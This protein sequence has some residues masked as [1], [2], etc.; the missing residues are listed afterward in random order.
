VKKILI[1][2]T[3]P[4]YFLE[5]TLRLLEVYKDEFYGVSSV[6][7]VDPFAL[8]SLSSSLTPMFKNIET[9]PEKIL[10]MDFDI[11]FNLS[12]NENSWDFH[13]EVNSK[14]KL[15]SQ[16]TEAT[17]LPLIFGLLTYLL[18]KRPLLI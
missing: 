2:Q 4:I 6:L 13:Q 7:Y 3:D 14:N 11:S 1:I 8:K 5:E 10:E 17:L 15:A 18:L 16:E 9:N 12:L